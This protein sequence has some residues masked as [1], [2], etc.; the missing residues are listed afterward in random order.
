MTVGYAVQGLAFKIEARPEFG[1]DP[2]DFSGKTAVSGI[3][4]KRTGRAVANVD[5]E[6]L[7]EEDGIRPGF[8][9]ELGDKDATK[10]W[11]SGTLEG[12]LVIRNQDD[13]PL[14]SEVFEIEVVSTI[15]EIGDG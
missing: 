8:V 15:S 2:Q 9:F 5:G 3:R 4:H 6:L 14:V 10:S 7:E 11:P 13:T 1:G 12:D